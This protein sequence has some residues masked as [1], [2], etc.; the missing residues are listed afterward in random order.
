MLRFSRSQESQ[1][2]S[3]DHRMGKASLIF[4]IILISWVTVFLGPDLA[5]SCPM[6]CH[7]CRTS[8]FW[9]A[10]FSI[11]VFPLIPEREQTVIIVHDAGSA[12]CKA[13][14]VAPENCPCVPLIIMLLK[15]Y[16]DV[17]SV[18]EF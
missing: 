5:L 8:Y 17:E 1:S 18:N 9:V 7:D 13:L 2:Q 11:T 14:S 3:H 10:D 12:A 15:T 16:M 4:P 6:V